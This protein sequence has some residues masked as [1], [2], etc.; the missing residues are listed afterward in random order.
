LLC[1]GIFGFCVFHSWCHNVIYCFAYESKFCRR[2][3]LFRKW[4][5]G[6]AE[7]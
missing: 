2:H 4:E 7:E 3:L 1:I 6:Q 5:L